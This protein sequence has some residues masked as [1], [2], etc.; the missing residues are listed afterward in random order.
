MFN[1][2]LTKDYNH[3]DATLEILIMLVGAFLLGCLLCW[4]IRKLFTQKTEH[5]DVKSY[6]S[7][8]YL[9]PKDVTNVDKTAYSGTKNQTQQNKKSD[10]ATNTTRLDDLTKIS[11][12]DSNMSNAL[13][14]RGINSYSDLRDIQQEKLKEIISNETNKT[15]VL[16]EI[17][18]WPHQAS[19]AAKGEWTRLYDYQSFVQRAK[20]ASQRG[21]KPKNVD[22]LKRIEGIGPK[23]ER[24]LNKKGIYTFEQLRKTESDTLKRFIVIEDIRFEKNETESWPHQAGMAEKGQWEELSIYQEFM[25]YNESD[26]INASLKTTKIAKDLPDINQIEIVSGVITSD[27]DFKD[28]ASLENKSQ[29]TN[30]EVSS[31]NR[32]HIKLLDNEPDLKEIEKDDLKKIDG[33]GPKIE[34]VLNRNGIYTF[35]KL[36]KTDR[37]TLKRY[38]DHAGPQ[39]KMHEPASWPHQAGMAARE[40]WSD[41]KTYQEFMDNGRGTPSE[42]ESA[43]SP[44]PSLYIKSVNDKDDLKKIEGIGPKIEILLQEAGIDTFEKLKNKDRD[45]LK[46]ILDAAGPQY[47]MHEPETWPLQAGMAS[48]KEWDKLEEYQGFLLGKRD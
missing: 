37:N 34:A 2:E 42:T 3:Q 29:K 32:D 30:K 1:S 17:E 20:A 10:N 26:E 33:I 24:I 6:S 46:A 31:I 8:S 47:R 39:F 15:A 35:D 16:K 38:L 36:H 4:L 18:T 25:E 11:G 12:I 14:K 41:L 43:S 5:M 48:K 13:K 9:N 40:E 7:S 22:D 27:K 28:P 21:N 44:S 19:L 45:T 23:I